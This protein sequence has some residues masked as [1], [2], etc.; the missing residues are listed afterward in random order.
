MEDSI[1][2]ML[3]MTMFGI[4]MVGA[5]VGGFRKHSNEQLMLRWTQLATFYPFMR[6]HNGLHHRSQEYYQWSSVTDLARRCFA[7]R[8]SLLPYWYTLFYEAATMSKPVLHA[9]SWLYPNDKETLANARQFLLGDKLLISPVLKEDE[10]KVQAYFPQDIWY[11]LHT[12]TVLE[13]NGWQEISCTLHDLVPVHV[14]AGSIVPMWNSPANNVAASKRNSKLQLWIALDSI[15]RAAGSCYLDNDEQ[16]PSSESVFAQFMF[17]KSSFHIT[18][19]EQ[20]GNTE[21]ISISRLIIAGIDTP[22][23]VEL[24]RNGKRRPIIPYREQDKV[25]L[26]IDGEVVDGDGFTISIL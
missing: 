14:R 4:P 12:G 26:E 13:K 7:L 19:M 18:K 11:D 15:G 5:D 10:D 2:G 22:K 3:A 16:L 8:Y 6:N 21:V 9:L 17:E 23:E 20:V 24:M 1:S 25:I